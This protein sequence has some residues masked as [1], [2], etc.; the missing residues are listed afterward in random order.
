[1]FM[2]VIIARFGKLCQVSNKLWVVGG[3]GCVVLE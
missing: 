1:M 2:V 3:D